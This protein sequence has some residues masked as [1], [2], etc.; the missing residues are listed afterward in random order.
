MKKLSV[1]TAILGLFI[2]NSCSSSH[3]PKEISPSSTDFTSGELAKLIEVVDAPCQLSYVEKDGTI[4]SQYLML[5]VQLRLT[6]ESPALQKA[7]P[8]DIDFTSLTSVATVNLVDEN[9]L[10]VQE[11]GVKQ[12][13]LLKL[14]KLVQKKVGD[15]ETIT[16]AGEFYDPKEAIKWF[17]QTKSF[18]PNLTGGLASAHTKPS[19][20][21]EEREELGLNLTGKLG[22]SDD[23]VLTYDENTDEGE[24]KFTVNGVLNVRKV[25]MGSYDKNS[26]TLIL[27]EFF[28]NGNY[29]GDFKGIWKDGI[30]QGVFTNTQGGSV[31][32]ILHGTGNDE[33][34]GAETA[35]SHNDNLTTGTGGSEDWDALL[36]A[37]EE[38][39][40]KY[41]SYVRKAANGD[42]T[43]LVEYPSLME[44]AQEFS[45]KLQK[46]QGSMSSSQLARYNNITMKMMK[47]AEEL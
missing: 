18:I 12:E 43:A 46:A 13:D 37:Y 3:E 4:E 10:T 23:A 38:Y 1:L 2:L 44:K 36:T 11:L 25:K 20:Y 32:F 6:K 33:F 16:F 28:A 39:V 27:K 26:N 17:E 34:S 41:I 14:K 47:A 40:D 8:R 19:V 9:G 22:G 5:K 42:M 15:V 21:T 7:D 29:V 24:L 35:K 31:D 45:N 30:Y